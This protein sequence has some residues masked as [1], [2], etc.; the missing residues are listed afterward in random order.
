MYSMIA[1]TNLPAGDFYDYSLT[2]VNGTT[3]EGLSR[4]DKIKPRNVGG[5]SVTNPSGMEIKINCDDRFPGGWG[6]KEGPK[7]GV[8]TAW[9]VESYE[10]AK[11]KDGKLNKQCSGDDLASPSSAPVNGYVFE[12]TFVNGLVLTGTSSS[13]TGFLPGAGGPSVDSPTGMTVHVSC[14]DP[15]PGG[16]GE[17]DG[18]K[19][20]IDTAWQVESYSVVKY[21]D[22][23]I[24]KT[25]G[26]S[27]VPPEPVGVPAVDIEMYVNGEDADMPPGVGMPVLS[28]ATLSYE[29]TNTGETPLTDVI[30]SDDALAQ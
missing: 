24:S 15:Y 23:A 13:N 18:P 5:T 16:W 27:F 1:T 19:Q 30:V 8:D 2:F 10:L 22:G 25:C 20:N 12:F 14:S 4:D 21:K 11:Y 28:T 29:V 6:A 26:D 3:I 7:V 17:K 9:Q